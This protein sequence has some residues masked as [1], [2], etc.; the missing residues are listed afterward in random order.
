M[1]APY[2]DRLIA[3]IAAATTRHDANEIFYASDWLFVR[4]HPDEREAA[5]EKI[6]DLIREKP[7]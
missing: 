4:M 1:T 5:Y 6:D 7:E 2:I 3:E